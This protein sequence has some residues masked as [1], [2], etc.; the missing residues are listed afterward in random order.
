MT[1]ISLLALSDLKV[2]KTTFHVLM[3]SYEWPGHK[4]ITAIS[5]ILAFTDSMAV[6]PSLIWAA[7]RTVRYIMYTVSCTNRVKQSNSLY[8]LRVR[9][10]GCFP[11]HS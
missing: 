1:T 2:F 9:Q 10:L 11:G 7:N 8:V 5:L 6:P 4:T 3:K